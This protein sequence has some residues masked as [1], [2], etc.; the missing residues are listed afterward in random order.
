MNILGVTRSLRGP[1]DP[2]G[3]A[4]AGLVAG[5]TIRRRPHFLFVCQTSVKRDYFRREP[6]AAKYGQQTDSP[7]FHD[8]KDGDARSFRLS[9]HSNDEVG[10]RH[11]TTMLLVLFQ[12]P[13]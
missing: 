8:A 11:S 1:N 6:Q 3:N 12:L 5:W 9:G 10:I 2:S 7:D 13:G 4:A